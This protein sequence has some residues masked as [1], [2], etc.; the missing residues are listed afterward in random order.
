MRE[1]CFGS[2]RS[3][4]RA[5]PVLVSET[6]HRPSLRTPVHAHP[7]LCLHFVLRGLY[8]ESGKGETHRLEPGWFLFKPEGERHWN[9]FREVGA[10]TLRLELD[11]GSSPILEEALPARMT[12]LRAP[13]L[14]LLAARAHAELAGRDE[15]SPVIAESLALELFAGIARLPRSRGS[16]HTSSLARR[17]ADLLD[18]RF[19]EPCR[20]GLAAEEL[21]VE[22][23]TLA[24]VFRR[25]YGCS[26]GEYLRRCRLA[27]VARRLQGDDGPGLAELAADAGFADQSHMTRTFKAEFGV[28]PGRWRARYA[29]A[30]ARSGT[31][32]A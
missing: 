30:G 21:G 26:V 8:E 32:E 6:T 5:G 11:R 23:T 19:R 15:L 12:A 14:S 29:G 13:H 4:L 18:A 2:H 28:P 20:L 1:A 3:A 16:D 10:V 27:H 31:R 17:C 22:R 9:D 7:F 25:E 24:H